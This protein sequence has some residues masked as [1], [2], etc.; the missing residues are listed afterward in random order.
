MLTHPIA[1]TALLGG[2]LA[3]ALAAASAPVAGASPDLALDDPIYLQLARLRASGALP[4]YLGGMRPLSEARAHALLRAA[5]E[6]PPLRLVSGDLSGPWL[7]PVRRLRLRAVLAR[8]HLRPYST[9]L[10]PR[11]LA[12]GVAITC[13]HG[14]GRTCGEGAGLEWELDSAAGYG[15]W[16]SASTRVRAVFGRDAHDADLALDR[17]YASAELG[18]VRFLAGRDIVVLGP[19]ART[20]ALW[21]D[22]APPVDQLRL[23][24]SRP[25]PLLGS[26]GSIL[27]ASGVFFVGRLA[28]PQT[29]SGSLVDATRIQVDLLDTAELGLTHLIQLGGDGAPDFTFGDYVLEHVRHNTGGTTPAG[30][31]NHRLSADVA[32]SWPELAGLRVYYEVAAED[33][34]DEL[35]N[36][37]R[38]DADHVVGIEIDR[39]SR[40]AALL[41]E[42]TLTGVRSHEH[43]LF[44][45]GLTSRGRV[46]GAPLGPSSAS[47]H[48]G[49][50]LQPA[51][52]ALLAPWFE[53]VH[54]SSDLF[55]ETAGRIARV[56]DLPDEL[57]ARGGARA[58][59]LL[60][61]DLTLALRAL[62]ERVSTADFV[63]GSTRW[64]A[65]AEAALTWTPGWR[66][67]GQSF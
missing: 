5:A 22:H 56:E 41:V 19:S 23:S 47:A 21:G 10:H 8:D 28:D 31:A 46:A 29:F 37:L 39:L 44:A 61:P 38:R 17:A 4:L 67:G 51:D 55:G 13:E 63:P 59:L 14:E 53:I 2:A 34:R 6:A 9:E 27:R 32:L 50:R 66:A 52:D 1:R 65:A 64:N 45:T 26:G 15:P 18:P 35:W 36:M 48:V 58:A 16:L 12:G 62:A 43:D 3:L 40:R 49:L 20:H 24:T 11:Y 60:S 33:M 42:L 30:F 54:Q 25:I 7:A 57:R